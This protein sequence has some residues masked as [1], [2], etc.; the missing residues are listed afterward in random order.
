[1]EIKGKQEEA[2]TT[3]G[4]GGR[5]KE[6]SAWEAFVSG[7]V[8]AKQAKVKLNEMV[9]FTRQLA[10][11]ISAGIPLLE[12]LEILAEQMEN[13]GFKVVLEEIVSEIVGAFFHCI[14]IRQERFSKLSRTCSQSRVSTFFVCLFVLVDQR[15]R[16][17]FVFLLIDW[18]RPQ[19]TAPKNQHG[20]YTTS[21]KALPHPSTTV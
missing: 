3:G 18:R 9:I 10:T 1:M 21:D 11:M 12:C 4:G 20:A 2:T 8:S 17:L 15:H 14:R 6:L 13:P 7:K 16:G 5:P 19:F